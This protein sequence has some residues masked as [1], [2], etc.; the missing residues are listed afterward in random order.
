MR[1]LLWLSLL[2]ASVASAATVEVLYD[3]GPSDQRI[4]LVILG[5]GYTSSDQAKLSE[6]ALSTVEGLFQETPYGEYR[7]LFNV[8]V[9]HLISNQNGADNGTYGAT[10][11]TA[12]DTYFNCGGIDR[13]LCVNTAKATAA[14]MADAPEFDVLVVIAN[15]PKYGGSGGAIGVISTHSSAIDLLR[16]ELSHTIAGLADEYEDPYPG[17]PACSATNDCPEPN[18]SL[19]GTRQ[20]LKW[21]AWLEPSTVVPTAESEGNTAIGAYEGCRYLKTGIYRPKDQGCLMKTLGATADF[22][23]VCR[24]GL[25]WSFWRRV[26]VINGL[27][28]A[29]TSAVQVCGGATLAVQTPSTTGGG[30]S[31]LWSVDGVPS[32][33][34]SDT[35]TV[36]EQ[37]STGEHT[38]S[39]V[40]RDVTAMARNDP[41]GVLTQQAQWNVQ[42]CTAGICD[43]VAA[44]SGS[45]CQTTPK[46]SGA[47]CGQASCA[48][49]VQTLAATCDGAG[50]CVAITLSCEAYTCDDAALTCRTSCSQDDHCAQ[51]SH[52]VEGTCLTPPS[53]NTRPGVVV[54]PAGGCGGCSSAGSA[55]WVGFALLALG[56]LRRRRASEHADALRSSAGPAPSPSPAGRCRFA[57]AGR[58]DSRS[59]TAPRA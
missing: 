40:A 21:A 29:N 56:T 48:D 34:T 25:I 16:H 12:L 27:V 14:A 54:P 41:D 51:G 53:K 2:V 19:R 23:S 26:P 6:D 5:D 58:S 52:C 37:V 10:R 20:T 18:A 49:G 44:C 4:D 43:E 45:T 42:A 28:P 46:A 3:N 22:C 1:G 9:I 11:D 38:I 57:R 31:F 7:A 30:Y 50:G 33:Q 8:K 32:A 15:D 59:R 55:N 35:F 39:V 47:V 13:L 17:Y 24:E 36:D